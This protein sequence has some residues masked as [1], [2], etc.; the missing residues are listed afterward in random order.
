MIGTRFDDHGVVMEV[1]EKHPSM[2]LEWWCRCVDHDTG[3]WLYSE[4]YIEQHRIK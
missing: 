2:V 1:V 4:Y 3:L